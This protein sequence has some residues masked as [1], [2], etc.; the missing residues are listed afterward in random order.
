ME[1]PNLV[2]LD[3]CYEYLL[4][5]TNLHITKFETTNFTN[6]TKKITAVDAIRRLADSII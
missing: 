5:G 6:E 2:K 4:C 3:M 1:T